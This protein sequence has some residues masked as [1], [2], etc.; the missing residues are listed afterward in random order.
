LSQTIE[1][2]FA[3]VVKANDSSKISFGLLWYELSSAL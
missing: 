3:L 1:P 2:S